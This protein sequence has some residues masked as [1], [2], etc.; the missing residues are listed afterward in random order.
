[1]GEWHEGTPSLKHG[2]AADCIDI[3]VRRER[4][5]STIRAGVAVAAASLPPSDA[6]EIPVVSGADDECE[7]CGAFLGE[8]PQRVERVH[9]D[10]VRAR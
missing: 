9:A 5:S 7:H 6:K 4:S 3:A 2:C 8:V 10:P 1:V